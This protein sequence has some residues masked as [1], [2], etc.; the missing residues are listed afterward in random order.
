MHRI[1]ARVVAG[2]KHL[3][4]MSS[5]SDIKCVLYACAGGELEVQDKQPLLEWLANNYKKFGCTLE[6]ITN[7]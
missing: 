5:A 1:L 7:K 2:F 3:W 4:M 6:F